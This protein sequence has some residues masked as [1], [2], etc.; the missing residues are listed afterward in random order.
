M[1]GKPFAGFAAIYTQ[2]G[3]GRIGHVY[4]KSIYRQYTD[5]TFEKLQPRPA[6][7]DYLGILG[8]ILHAEVGDTIK[9][10]FKNNGSRQ[11][12]IHPHGVF[13]EKPSE[14]SMY[15]DGVTDV[16][17]MGSMVAPGATFTYTWEVPERAGPGP[18]DPSSVVWLYHS[19]AN[20]LKDVSSGLIGA[21]VVTARGKARPDGS[22]ID[23]DREVVSLF[24]AFNEG[25][26]WFLDQ[27]MASHLSSEDR[28][29]VNKVETNTTDAEGNYLLAGT[30]FAE[31]NIK[32]S[33]NGYMYGNGPVI[34]VPLGKRVRWYL[35]AIGQGFDFHTP[36]WH[37]NTVLYHG[38]RT[39]T[40]ALSPAEM[41]TADMVPDD[42]GLWLFHCHVDDHMISG[43]VARYEVRHQPE[44]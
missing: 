38:H 16:Q 26:S 5:G 21:I 4:R 33:I 42:P 22:P 23:V 43:M 3:P 11:Y 17:K 18:S 28:A 34:Q 30:G 25:Q 8:P 31:V 13:Y 36:H 7:D 35:V 15:V 9:V 39:D 32:F 12:S 20:E 29:K 2:S 27:N 6:Q 40:I 1:T 44:R 10:V 41:E 24:T 37:G 19:H 14:G